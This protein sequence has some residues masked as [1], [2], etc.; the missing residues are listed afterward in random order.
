MMP[1]RSLV[2]DIGGTNARF[3]IAA[4]SDG[5]K[6]YTL[7]HQ[8]KLKASDFSLLDDAV[9]AYLDDAPGEKPK[10]ACLAVAAPIG[11]HDE[12]RFTNSPWSV[13]PT[14]LAS[15]AGVTAMRTV[16]DFMAL[17][18]GAITLAADE[19]ENVIEGQGHPHA[20]VVVLGPGTGLGASIVV[21]E[22][23][24][25]VLGTEG[26]HIAFAPQSEVEI[27]VYRQLQREYGYVSFELLLSGRG[28]VNIHR[29]VCTMSDAPFLDF[30]P[31]DITN[32]ALTNADEYP[33][34]RRA[35]DVFC[36]VL[37]TYAGNYV[38]ATGARGGVILGGGILPRIADLLRY[39]QFE[40]RFRQR[41][42]MSAYLDDVPVR[43][44]TV[45]DVA[46]RGAAAL[47][48]DGEKQ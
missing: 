43:L 6:P 20:P 5:D 44:V 33:T 2:A 27:E 7:E 17:A 13:K 42:P 41:G 46:L 3:A 34:T 39:S 35:V 23:P 19:C 40:E 15:A 45:D 4:P 38:V 18:R 21:R 8:R 9:R 32:A 1:A 11:D 16:N 25:R 31:A 37:G 48:D 10:R 36:A 12:V 30:D 47:L 14:T 29:A 26:G 22:E 24:V 28:L